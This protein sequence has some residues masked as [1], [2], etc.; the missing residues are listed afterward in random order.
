M[1]DK[2][3]IAQVVPPSQQPVASAQPYS[4]DP[5]TAVG[6]LLAV[7][8]ACAA[9]IPPLLKK[10]V[11]GA[12]ETRQSKTELQTLIVKTQAELDLNTKKDELTRA[13]EISS[14]YLETAKESQKNERELLILFVTKE[15]DRS[16]QSIDQLYALIENYKASTEQLEACN[17][18]LDSFDTTLKDILNVLK[19]RERSV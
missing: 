3:Y 11:G 16:A 9:I 10:W 5:V 14:F 2:T 7:V 6:Y 15:L 8:G 1:K 4:V 18:K 12:I 17:K 19:M 13:N